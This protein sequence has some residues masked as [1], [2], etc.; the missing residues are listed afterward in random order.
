MARGDTGVGASGGLAQGDHR[1]GLVACGC[2]TQAN[3]S[4]RVEET[5]GEDADIEGAGR[6]GQQDPETST[7]GDHSGKWVK[8]GSGAI[9]SLADPGGGRTRKSCAGLAIIEIG[10]NV[11]DLSEAAFGLNFGAESERLEPA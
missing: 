8:L 5:V 6:V 10:E 3:G 11:F 2:T 4:R 7:I 1:R 9:E